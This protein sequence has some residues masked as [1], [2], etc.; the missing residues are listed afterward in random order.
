V[1]QF[2]P[3][4]SAEEPVDRLALARWLVSDENPLAAR[5][6]VNRA[7]AALF[8]AGFLPDSADFGTQSSPP[9][10]PALLDWLAVR[11]RDGSDDAGERRVEP[12]D[13]K[14]LHRLI[15]T[16]AAYRQRSAATPER[17]AA[18]PRNALLS[19][20][21]RHRLEAELVRDAALAASGLL[22][23]KVGGPPV[24]PPQ[25][26]SVTDLAYGNFKWT[27]SVG[28]DRFR[29]SVYTFHKRTAPFAAFAVFDAPS[30]ERCV[31]DRGRSNTPL[32]A[33]TLLNDAMFLEYARALGGRVVEEADTPTARAERLFRLVLTRR[34]T[35]AERAAV[36]RF[37]VEQ[38]RRVDRGEL[39][40]A[41]I[42]HGPGDADRAAWTLAARAALNLDEAV[43]K[44]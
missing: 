41:E 19:R 33:L 21:P 44:E 15:V 1:P 23:E 25:P 11:F 14:A 24:M 39:D 32:Q 3:Q 38:R 2:L 29:R 30:G 43:T 4:L 42:L 28:E 20:G 31:A 18:D 34:P 26:A 22:V 7:W 16:S 36:E 12:W 27:P 8:G 37:A 6:A 17:A 40:A 13:V 5:V 9:S 10:H 35:P